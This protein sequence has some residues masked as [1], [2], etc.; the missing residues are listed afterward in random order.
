MERTLITGRITD[1]VRKTNE[2][3]EHGG[4]TRVILGLLRGVIRQIPQ[5]VRRERAT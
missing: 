2:T 5:V 4:C 1:V 3:D